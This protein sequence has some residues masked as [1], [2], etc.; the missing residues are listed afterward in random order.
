MFYKRVVISRTRGSEVLQVIEE[1]L[2]RPQP[3]EVRVKI[4]TAGVAFGDIL[5]R[6]GARPG[7]P[8]LPFSPGY[9][10]VGLVDALEE[11]VSTWQ[12][13]QRVAAFTTIGAHAAFLCV[14][15]SWLV[16]VPADLDAAEAVSL[17]LNYVTAYHLLN[18]TAQIQSGERILIHD[19]AGGVGMALLQLGKLAGVEMYG[20][21]SRKKHSLVTSSGAV[22]I[23]Y[24]QEDFVQRIQDLTGDGVD[25]VFDPI[26]GSH[27]WR[28]HR[29]LRQGSRL[30][31]YGISAAIRNRRADRLTVPLSLAMY[32]YE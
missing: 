4:L 6:L 26:G 17:V 20:T 13:G 28:S 9:D 14:P 27:F 31:A 11:G 23:N 12:V 8:P 5:A 18:R 32:H 30:V 3:G 2:P 7:V 24:Q 19:A 16:A 10:L 21:A 29:V 1:K 25:A 22:A 15:A